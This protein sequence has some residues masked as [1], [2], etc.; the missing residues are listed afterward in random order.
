MTND[1]HFFR[2]RRW[3]QEFND[4][5]DE[6]YDDNYNLGLKPEF[7]VMI[8]AFCLPKSMDQHFLVRAIL[9]KLRPPVHICD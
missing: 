5:D 6:N 8:T 9:Q 4:N 3:L 2:T 7:E 1:D